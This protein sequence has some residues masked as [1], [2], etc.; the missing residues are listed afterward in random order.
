MVKKTRGRAPS[1]DL[2]GE[3]RGVLKNLRFSEAEWKLVQEKMAEAK[4]Q[5]FSE[6]ARLA[7]LY[8]EFFDHDLLMVLKRRIEEVEKK[9]GMECDL[10][11]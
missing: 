3:R 9:L 8:L 1:C 11:Y 7:C 4:I 10:K 6:Y 2:K 5:E